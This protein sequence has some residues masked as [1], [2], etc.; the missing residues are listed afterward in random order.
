[1]KH[2]SFKI[3]L[4]CLL[5]P[6]LLYL[7]TF[8]FAEN[9]FHTRYIHELEN[10]YLGDTRRLLDGN[11]R[12]KD[13]I[14]D[15]VRRYLNSKRL[16]RYGFRAKVTVTTRNGTLLY[17]A[18][19]E[20]AGENQ[21]APDPTAVATENYRLLQEEP[22]LDL[23]TNFEHLK[24]LPN[25]VLGFYVLLAALALYGHYRFAVRKYQQEDAQKET[26]IRRLIEKENAASKRLGKIDGEKARLFSELQ[27]LRNTLSDQQ[28]RA[29]RS[30]NELFEEIETLEADLKRTLDQQAQQ[31]HEI[32]A[33]K[34]RIV[35]YERKTSK[36]AKKPPKAVPV[37]GKRFKTLYKKIVI[38]EHALAGYAELDEKIKIKAEEVIHQLNENPDQVAIKRKVF[39]GKRDQ[40][41]IQEVIFGYK[42][43]LY[44]RKNPAGVVEV[45]AVGDK[46]S[47]ARELAYLSAL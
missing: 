36:S 14:G 13:A 39:I 9:Y 5:L 20:Q 22:V 38:S 26:E 16:T 3:L 17:P 28:R 18:V 33:L 4:V 7:A 1:M 6:P 37:L 11:V 23:D 30:E 46:N 2:F 42:G 19:F 47:Q 31:H 29:S 21:I 10:I 24:P 43:R 41:S 45:L 44:F 40:K 25:L 8:R 34:D 27:R 35:L 12:L 15:N 32:A